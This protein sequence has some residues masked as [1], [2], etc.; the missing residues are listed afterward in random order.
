VIWIEILQKINEKIKAISAIAF[1]AIR[2]KLPA[3]D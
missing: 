1:L 3:V 2:H